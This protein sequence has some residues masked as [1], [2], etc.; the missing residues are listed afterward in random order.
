[1]RESKAS[2]GI[3]RAKPPSRLGRGTEPCET[4][5]MS[6]N[7]ITLKYRIP[8]VA[9]TE[10]LAAWDGMRG[11]KRAGHVRAC[12]EYENRCSEHHH[13]RNHDRKDRH[14]RHT[15]A[16]LAASEEPVVTRVA[17]T[18]PEPT[19]MATRF[20]WASG[21]YG[22][23]KLQSTSHDPTWS[24]RNPENIGRLHPRRCTRPKHGTR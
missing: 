19:T 23:P 13:G 4:R 5:T 24:L 7:G 9:A 17:H 1:M 18:A 14:K 16:Y 12:P 20:L 15:V 21:Y 3:K 6:H 2:I 22:M 8:L 11:S 10:H